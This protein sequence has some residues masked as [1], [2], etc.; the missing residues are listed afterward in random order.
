MHLFDEL[1]TGRQITRVCFVQ[2]YL[3]IWFGDV[4]LNIYNS[5][6]F[7]GGS[8]PDFVGETVGRT[9]TS[10]D[11]FTLIFSNGREL[12]V[13]LA[14]EDYQSPEAMLLHSKQ[15]GYVTWP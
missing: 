6:D 15:D 13:G 10:E 8:A 1:L 14:N 5:I 7:I 11:A 4:S 9:S 2:D 12:W 3:Q